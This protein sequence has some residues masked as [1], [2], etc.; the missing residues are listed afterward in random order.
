MATV[1]LS[2]TPVHLSAMSTRRLPLS[3][4]PNAANSPLRAS[5]AALMGLH[6]TKGLKVRSHADMMRE[7][8]YGQPPPPK[9]QMVDHSVQRV[10]GSPTRSRASRT[11]VHRAVTRTAATGTTE[12]TSQSTGYK[13]SEKELENIRQWQTQIRARFPKMVFYF[14][15]IPDDHRSRLSKQVVQL[16]AVSF[17]LPYSLVLEWTL[18]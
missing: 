8:P 2:P 14:E 1:S 7:E 11:I 10:P 3:S 17:C 9:R 4:N 6:G 18:I 13:P 12:R 16:G 5:S 15:S